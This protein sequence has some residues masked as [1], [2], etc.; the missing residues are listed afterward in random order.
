MAEPSLFRRDLEEVFLLLERAHAGAFVGPEQVKRCKALKGKLLG[1]PGDVGDVARIEQ[2]QQHVNG[3][4]T[5]LTVRDY[6][7]ARGNASRCQWLLSE[8]LDNPPAQDGLGA[9]TQAEARS[10][11]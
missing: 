5:H 9:T 6:E 11:P 4:M 3:A 1:E 2:A 8:V 10:K 7:G